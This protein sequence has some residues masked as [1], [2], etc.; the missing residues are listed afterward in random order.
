MCLHRSL[1]LGVTLFLRWGLTEHGPQQSD[2]T[3]WSAGSRDSSVFTF[4]VLE[5]Q[6]HI[7]TT[8]F[9]FFLNRYQVLNWDPY[10][11]V[12]SSLLVYWLS[13]LLRPSSRIFL[14]G[15]NQIKEAS[16]HWSCAFI[17][18]ECENSVKFCLFCPLVLVS[19]FFLS[20]YSDVIVWILWLLLWWIIL[21][22]FLQLDKF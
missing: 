4:P 21:I 14:E 2:R 10:S 20:Y 11:Y 17:V 19:L 1:T 6:G 22:N 16:N 5:L 13:H 7:P 8:G 12:A 18:N 9:F 3:S 15:F